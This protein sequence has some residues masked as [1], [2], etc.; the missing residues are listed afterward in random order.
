VEYMTEKEKFMDNISLLYTDKG[1]FTHVSFFLIG[2][3]IT[4]LIELNPASQ[5]LRNILLFLFIFSLFLICALKIKKVSSYL[6]QHWLRSYLTFLGIWL[7]F[8]ISIGY[9][10]DDLIGQPYASWAAISIAII[11]GVGY[12]LARLIRIIQRSTSKHDLVAIR[13]LTFF[14]LIVI[15]SIWGV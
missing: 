11:I 15:M 6:K 5:G 10:I 12:V 14:I 4:Y 13:V 2:G 8:V 7:G 1:A 3:G 9:T